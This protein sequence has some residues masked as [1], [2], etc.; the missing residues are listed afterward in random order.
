MTAFTRQHDNDSPF[1]WAEIPRFDHVRTHLGC[2]QAGLGHH[3]CRYLS[4]APRP[5][6]WDL[7]LWW[8][9]AWQAAEGVVPDL[10]Q[11]RGS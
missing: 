5:T 8:L 11:G 9:S 6:G 10:E 7:L 4:E 1:S 2:L 3:L